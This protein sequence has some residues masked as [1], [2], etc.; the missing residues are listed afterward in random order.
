MFYLQKDKYESWDERKIWI[1]DEYVY[2][3]YILLIV[4]GNVYYII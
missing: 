3:T 2:W 4:L 1:F